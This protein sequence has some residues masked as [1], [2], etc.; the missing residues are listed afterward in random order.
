MA[1]GAVVSDVVGLEVSSSVGAVSSASAT[2]LASKHEK[3]IRN[4]EK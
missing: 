3:M 1:G 2:G 4:M